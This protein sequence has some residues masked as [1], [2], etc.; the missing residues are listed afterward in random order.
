[1]QSESW[2]KLAQRGDIQRRAIKVGLLVGT[3]LALIN[4]GDR[5][6]AMDLDTEAISRILLTY[7]VPYSVS[8]WS[9][10]QTARDRKL[11]A[12]QAYR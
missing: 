4:H 12:S 8:T 9:S 3:L 7:L 2:L 1:M 5:L 10:V 6:L 11:D